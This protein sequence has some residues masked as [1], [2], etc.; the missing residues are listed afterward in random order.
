VITAMF[1]RV[2]VE[3]SNHNAVDLPGVRDEHQ[4]DMEPQAA[5]SPGVGGHLFVKVAGSVPSVAV[6]RAHQPAVAKSLDIREVSRM[7]RRIEVP[8]DHRG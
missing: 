8:S 6:I 5:V 4:V 7:I 1:A 3:W 2:S